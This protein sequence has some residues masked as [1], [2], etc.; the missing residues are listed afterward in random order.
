LLQIGLGV[1]AVV[2]GGIAIPLIAA[3]VQFWKARGGS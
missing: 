3:E 1:L 2:G